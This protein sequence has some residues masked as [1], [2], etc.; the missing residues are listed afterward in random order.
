MSIEELMDINVVSVSK[1]VQKLIDTPAAITV[2]TAEEI[3]RHGFNSIPEALR[4]ASGVEVAQID[5]NKW[6]VSIRGSNGI[7]ANKLLVMIDGRTVYTPLFSGTYW[8]TQDTMIE[9][10]AKIEVVRGPGGT[11]WGANAVN[12]VINVITKHSN[13]T[14]GGLVTAGSGGREGSF[15]SFRYGASLGEQGTYRIFAKNFDRQ[16]HLATPGNSAADGWRIPRGGFRVDLTPSSQDQWMITG[17]GYQGRAGQQLQLAMLSPPYQQRI[18]D[19]T[20]IS[21]GFV[22]TRWTHQFKTDNELQI[23]GS[24]N[25]NIRIEAPLQEQRTT[26]DFD[27]QHQFTW[28]NHKTNWG[29]TLRLGHDHIKGSFTTSFTIP[30]RNSTTYSAFVQDEV[31]LFQQRLRITL[32]SKF[33]HNSYTGFEYQPSIRALWQATDHQV[34]WAAISRAVQT[35]SRSYSDMQLNYA[36]IPPIPFISTTPTLLQVNGNTSLKAQTLQAYELGWRIKPVDDLSIDLTGYYHRYNRL[37]TNEPNGFLVTTTPAPLHNVIQRTY[38]NLMFGHSYGVELSSRWQ[39]TEQWRLS[40]NYSHLTMQ[41]RLN[42]ASQDTNGIAKEVGNSPSQL[43]S[44]QSELNLPYA[45]ELDGAI[46]HSAKLHFFN[47]LQ[48]SITP[49]PAYTRLDLRLGW[50][51][52]DSVKLSLIGQNLLDKQHIQFG[53]QNGISA[54]AVPRSIYAKLSWLF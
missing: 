7:Y 44:L 12:G 38:G 50:Q 48:R 34:V 10:I 26:W 11:L 5:A 13:D 21:G 30:R 27:L 19:S 40:T 53:N 9:D 28:G 6:A 52:I 36:V 39:V 31:Q 54:T 18:N 25:R 45:I 22:Q 41:L 42:A 32:G 1:T 33:E 15:A 37:I 51:A 23:Q 2:I 29:T 43:Y 8:N 24:V 49:I 46:Y 47:P 20:R 3:R 17:E 14:Q 4:L 35:P 16:P